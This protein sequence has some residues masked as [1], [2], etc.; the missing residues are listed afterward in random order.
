MLTVM[1]LSV[2]VARA[3]MAV[4]AGGHQRH[5]APQDRG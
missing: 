5:I 4:D 3:Q 1:D 2:V